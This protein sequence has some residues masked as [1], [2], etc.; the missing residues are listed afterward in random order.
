MTAKLGHVLEI[1]AAVDV[2]AFYYGF[3]LD[4][5][6]VGRM[7][8]DVIPQ[9]I[10]HNIDF[11]R[12][13]LDPVV[14]VR[15]ILH[16][17]QMIEKLGLTLILQ[18]A[19]GDLDAPVYAVEPVVFLE[20]HNVA[21]LDVLLPRLHIDLRRQRSIALLLLALVQG[22][23]QVDRLLLE[24]LTLHRR[25]ELADYLVLRPQSLYI[26]WF[27]F[28][29]LQIWLLLHPIQDFIQVLL[30]HNFPMRVQ[31]GGLRFLGAASKV[32][33]ARLILLAN[34]RRYLQIR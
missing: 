32:A 12:I 33:L 4:V 14:R 26:L 8:D 6:V 31:L 2:V 15:L 34:D 23:V 13:V 5:A 21:R 7:R 22:F 19:V 11:F 17:A 10:L 29:E 9:R 24:F 18:D 1:S 20:F 30:D 16:I 27:T 28:L 25:L 3:V